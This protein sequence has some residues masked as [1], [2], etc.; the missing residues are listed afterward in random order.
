MLTRQPGRVIHHPAF[1]LRYS[2]ARPPRPVKLR[3]VVS[4]KL[5]KKA[6]ERN[7]LRRRVREIW[8]VLPVTTLP[9]VVTIYM[10][11][12]SLNMSFAELRM[13]ITRII[14]RLQS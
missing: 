14:P 8:R 1:T 11:S 10:K 9:P 2:G 12:L 6:T 3:V 13:A 5:S 4:T 7:R